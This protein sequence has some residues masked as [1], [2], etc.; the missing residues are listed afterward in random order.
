MITPHTPRQFLPQELTSEVRRTAP[1]ILTGDQMWKLYH[2]VEKAFARGHD[3]G[4][5]RGFI[6]GQD[7]M[8]RPRAEKVKELRDRMATEGVLRGDES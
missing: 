8:R 6:E 2:L 3:E 5:T 1:D 7:A 4:Y